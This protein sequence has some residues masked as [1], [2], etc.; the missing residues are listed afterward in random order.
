MEA[1]ITA[2]CLVAELAGRLRSRGAKSENSQSSRQ[3]EEP[4]MEAGIRQQP[5]A[6]NPIVF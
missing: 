2:E 6:K 4:S 1:E 5:V 3:L